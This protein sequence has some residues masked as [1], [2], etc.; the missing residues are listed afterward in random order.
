M[1]WAHCGYS[2]ANLKSQCKQ[3]VARHQAFQAALAIE[4]MMAEL[5]K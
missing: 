2:D 4:K 1:V 3:A 5:Q